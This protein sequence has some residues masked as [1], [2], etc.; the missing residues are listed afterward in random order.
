M[1]YIIIIIS[2]RVYDVYI[3]YYYY[4]NAEII[5]R[6]A[7]CDYNIVK[8]RASKTYRN[9]QLVPPP[10]CRSLVREFINK[11]VPTRGMTSD[12]RRLI[13]RKTTATA[14]PLGGSDCINNNMSAGR[15]IYFVYNRGHSVR[16]TAN[17]E[18]ETISRAGSRGALVGTSSVMID[19]VIPREIC[20]NRVAL[21]IKYFI[22]HNHLYTN[23]LLLYILL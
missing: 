23:S 3:I 8:G 19:P 7:E 15:N 17:S 4:G 11:A 16:Q 10:R 13:I 12:E 21:Y 2:L 1:L 5:E 18:G 20:K 9:S 6:I 14:R 22:I